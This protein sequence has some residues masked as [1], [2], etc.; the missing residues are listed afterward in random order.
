MLKFSP[1]ER[2]TWVEIYKHEVLNNQ[3]LG[4]KLGELNQELLC[5]LT[6][7]KIDP[8]N[9]IIYYTEFSKKERESNAKKE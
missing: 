3:N 2:I 6:E 7:S 8:R 9:H 4:S 5:D 1:N